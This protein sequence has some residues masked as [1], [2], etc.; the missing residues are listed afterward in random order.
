MNTAAD[1]LTLWP[2]QA[3][4]HAASVDLLFIWFAALVAVLSAPVFILL[5]VFAVRYRRG[6]DVDRRHALHRSVWLEASWAVVPFLLVLG[7]FAWATWLY[8]DLNRPPED[9]LEI[10]VV[11]KQWMWKVQHPGGQREINELHVPTGQPVMLTMTSQDVIHSFYLPALR[12]KQ[13]VVPGMFTN[14]WFEVQKPGTYRLTCTE[15]C[16]T[17][18]A[19]MGG[20][21]YALPPEAYAEWLERADAGASLARQG[22]ALFRRYG[23]SGCHGVASEVQAPSLAGLYGSPVPLASGEVVIA[24]EQY[25]HDSIVLPKRAVAAGYEPIMPTFANLL[26]EEDVLKLVAYIKSLAPERWRTE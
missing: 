21:F 20:T 9:A 24:D 17:G 25:I 6:K 1:I 23:C 5:A 19:T 3:S 8:V 10:N 4:E 12:L 22:E 16:G 11:A 15:F 14:M 13:D 26:S 7:F 2:G 18:H